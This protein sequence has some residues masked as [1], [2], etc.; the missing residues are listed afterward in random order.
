MS[1]WRMVV[2][3][4]V[5]LSADPEAVKKEAPAASAAVT[6]AWASMARE[7]EQEHTASK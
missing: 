3:F 6:C 2:S 5:W 4:L 7:A 1:M